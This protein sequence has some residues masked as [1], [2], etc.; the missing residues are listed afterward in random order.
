MALV[1][2]IVSGDIP[3]NKPSLKKKV[4]SFVKIIFDLREQAK[5]VCHFSSYTSSQTVSY[6][7]LVANR[8]INRANMQMSS[9]EIY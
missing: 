5:K 9:S 1:E 6:V 3:D 8:H 4:A 7:V 2:G